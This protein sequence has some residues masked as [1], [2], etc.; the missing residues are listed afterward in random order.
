[1]PPNTKATGVP[2]PK[3]IGNRRP[4]AS[5][6]EAK[7]TAAEPPSLRNMPLRIPLLVRPLRGTITI[8]VPTEVRLD[9]AEKLSWRTR[10]QGIWLGRAVA[11]NAIAAS[12]PLLAR[13]GVEPPSP[14]ARNALL[15]IRPLVV[16]T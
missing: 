9:T 6:V 12:I 8:S 15:T 7:L 14:L 1:M 13:R 16:T 5:A 2:R 10:R 4:S 11:K 3:E